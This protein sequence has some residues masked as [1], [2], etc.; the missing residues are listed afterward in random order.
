MSRKETVTKKLQEISELKPQGVSAEDI[1]GALHINRSTAS[2]YLNDLFQNG[3]A[4]KITGKPVR[5]RR[6][7]SYSYEEVGES[8]Q[9]LVQQS[10]AALAYPF[11][12][13]PILFT[14]ETG[15]GKTYLAERL[16]KLAVQEGYIKP[17][18][19]FITFNCADYA[20]NPEL[21]VGQIFGIKK[22]A[23]T[24]SVQD[25]P[26]LVEQADGGILFLD[27]IHRLSSSGQEMLFYL[28]DKGVYR[29]LGEATRERQA[30]ITFIGATTENP[31]RA[32]L[33]TLLRRFSVTLTVPP[34]R[35]RSRAEREML[36]DLF[37]QQEAVQMDADLTMEDAGREELLS[38][39]CPGNIGQLKSDIQIACARAYLR[40]L[41]T[42]FSQVVV[43]AEDISI[44]MDDR[45]SSFSLENE[46]MKGEWNFPFPNIYQ[47]LNNKRVQLSSAGVMAVDSS[48]QDVVNQ[49]IAD[50]TARYPKAAFSYDAWHDLVDEDLLYALQR[51]P[52]VL[53]PQIK[54]E[55]D[56]HSMCVIGLHL[57]N[58]RNHG[59]E[60]NQTLPSFSKA[61]PED[62]HAASRLAEY[63]IE[64]IGLKLPDDEVELLAHFLTPGEQSQSLPNTQTI[65]VLLV[66]HGRS[67][68]SS[69]AEVTNTLLGAEVIQSVDMPLE[70][71][72]EETYEEVRTLIDR[73]LASNTYEGV[74]LLVDMGS[75]VT[76]GDTFYNE[77]EVPVFT[78]PCVNMPMVMEA[79]RKSLVQDIAVEDVYTSARQ[80]MTMFMREDDAETTPRKKRM[81]AT[82]CFTG[83]GAAQLLEEWLTDQLTGADSDVVIRSVRMDPVSRDTSILYQLKDYYEIVAIIGTVYISMDEIPFIPAWEL[84]KQEGTSRLFK[85]LEVSRPYATLSGE[86]VKQHHQ[87]GYRAIQTGLAEIVTNVN[88]RLFCAI[89]DEYFPPIQAYYGWDDSRAL[90]MGMHIGVLL[91][92]IMN[93]RM[94][95]EMEEL[96]K[97]MPMDTDFQ[98]DDAEKTVWEPLIFNL[99]QAF[100]VSIA[101]S[102]VRATMKLAR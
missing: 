81:I 23:F 94:H 30:N 6:K 16:Y 77:W 52:T 63:L 89:L 1:A 32:L 97:T 17:S 27:E 78:L 91:D 38:Y 45:P 47:R 87:E 99:E 9:P 53:S 14:G 57:Q 58:L 31:E 101:P 98:H 93:A 54:R 25:E 66:T 42:D 73:A 55:L 71:S 64:T 24:G 5:Y 29:R 80:A 44:K 26:G 92:R 19:P 76:L 61:S 28:I 18:T 60:N 102:F 51:A 72:A 83:E 56:E 74:L 65:F 88:P 84:L 8:L 68:A 75:L 37:L 3:Q 85:L 49:Y 86:T 40:Y 96:Q 12:S 7:T 100:N 90:G 20:Q 39:S 22:G 33:T 34:L 2:R 36:L 70:K 41:N 95:G 21:L 15:T 13:L 79:G 43:R 48:L 4:E 62:R 50:L 10:L 59:R 11:Q 35:V 67:A 46:Q 69:M 82:V